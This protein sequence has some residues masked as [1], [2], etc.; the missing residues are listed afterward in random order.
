MI[1][2]CVM[3]RSV[4]SELADVS[5][6]YAT[7]IFTHPE[8]EGSNFLRNGAKCVLDYALLQLGRTYVLWLFT[9]I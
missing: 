4:L 3:A 9:A 2:L 5:E 8:E 1:A 6:E 7:F